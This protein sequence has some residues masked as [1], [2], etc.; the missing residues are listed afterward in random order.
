MEHEIE[1]KL[2]VEPDA[3]DRVLRTPALRGLREGR[4]RAERLVSVYFDTENCALAARGLALRIRHSGRS[5]VQTVKGPL[6]N[7]HGGSLQRHGEWTTEIAGDRPDLDR[8]AEPDLRKFLTRRK[9]KNGLEEVFRT[10]IHRRTV[11]LVFGETRAELAFDH[12]VIRSGEREEPVCEVELELLEGDP[13]HLYDI[14]LMLAGELPLCVEHRTKSARGYRLF[15]G[16]Q[17]V[18]IRAGGLDLAPA[19]TVRDAFFAIANGCLAQLRANEMLVLEGQDPEGIH[20][21]RV[22]VR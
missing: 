9:L 2:R 19:M 11:P 6:A 1:L 18:A 12:G 15:R 5:R 7:G 21:V 4:A 8:I 3:A 16:T 20:Q 22:S 17:P 10:E 14:A 13:S